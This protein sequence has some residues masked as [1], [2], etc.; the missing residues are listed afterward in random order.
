MSTT[1]EG[2]QPA[3]PIESAP[4]EQP[5]AE[6]QAPADEPLGS[7][8]KKAL[9]AERK[10]RAAAEMREKALAAKVKDFEDAHKSESEKQAE[11][12]ATLE[13]EAAQA[14]T[15]ILRYKAAAKHGISEEDAETFLTG[16]DEE[17]IAKQAARLAA[18][19]TSAASAVPQP[20]PGVHVPGEGRSPAAPNLDDQIAEA[21]RNRQFTQAIALKQQQAAAQSQKR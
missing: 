1:T 3:E 7:G 9:D 18:L 17:A 19:T 16:T 2:D 14:R 21:Q 11:R 12:L 5:A 20:Q 8:G 10:A 6:D 4:V 15:V 13:S